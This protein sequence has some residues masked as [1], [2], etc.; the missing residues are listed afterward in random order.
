MMKARGLLSSLCQ[1]LHTQQEE[2]KGE[3]KKK[4]RLEVLGDEIICHHR[5]AELS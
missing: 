4:R 5:P 2:E 1:Y 3:I